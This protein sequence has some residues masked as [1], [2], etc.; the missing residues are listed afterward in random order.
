MLPLATCCS[1]ASNEGSRRLREDFTITEE[2]PATPRVRGAAAAAAAAAAPCSGCWPRPWARSRLP[3]PGR[4]SAGSDAQDTFAGRVGA[5]HAPNWAVYKVLL[6]SMPWWLIAEAEE[7]E[8]RQLRSP[9]PF[10][11]FSQ[12]MFCYSI[13]YSLKQ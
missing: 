13:I 4:G 7:T 3:R 5:H 1:R 11:C 10:D 2:D 6:L 9:T 12:C 8:S